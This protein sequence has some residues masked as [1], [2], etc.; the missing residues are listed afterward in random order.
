MEL[1]KEKPIELET[2]VE[3]NI[4]D[5]TNPINIEKYKR[6][7]SKLI[8]EAKK[9]RKVSK[10]FLIRNDAFFP[11]EFKWKINSKDTNGEY[12]SFAYVPI[13]EEPKKKSAHGF[14]SIIS[15]FFEKKPPKSQSISK[16]EKFFLYFPVKFRITKHF[17]IN[18]ALGLELSDNP[19]VDP[20][21]PFTII[22]DIDNFLQSGYGFS[23]AGRD[24][25][26]DVAHE[27]LEISKNAILLISVDEYNKIK[28]TESIKKWVSSKR[29]LIVY[30]G[31]LTLAI[32]MLLTEKGALPT[33]TK[34]NSHDQETQD[35]IE[36]SFL[37]L[38]AKYELEYGT[39]HHGDH[40]S[41]YVEQYEKSEENLMKNFIAYI[42][43]E[44]G[45]SLIANNNP[46]NFEW[47]QYI[48]TI[49]IERFK[50]MLEK[51]N[52]RTKDA[53]EKNKEKYK[54]DRENITPEISNLFKDTVNLIK[55][56]SHNLNF[57]VADDELTKKCI[58][59]F[60]L[61][62]VAEQVECAQWIQNYLTSKNAVKK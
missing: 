22:D 54:K 42:N 14:K 17:T 25:Y 51:F 21:R 47:N 55:K 24:A 34:D 35:I 52:N 39:F 28:D 10:F 29:R 56:E 44:L 62:T 16:I 53:I 8:A 9:N 11:D 61:P 59:F 32:N 18:T 50:D 6:N 38:C 23:I 43:N 2:I 4:I 12:R 37:E 1:E 5:T 7:L 19:G 30:K 13:E 36:K 40:F 60:I 41:G 15:L 33:K 26:L 49:G 20:N 57:Q 48:K 58:Q 31:D 45:V 27:P 46:S 3:D